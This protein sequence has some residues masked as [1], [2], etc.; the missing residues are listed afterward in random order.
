[1]GKENEEAKD[2][3]TEKVIE[4]TSEKP[5][6]NATLKNHIIASMGVG[7][8][9]L[10]LVDLVALTGIQVNMLRK[11]AKSYD[12][13]FFQDKVKNILASL[14]GGGLP[15]TLSGVF[16]SLL[17]SV[18]IVGQT[19]GALAMTILAG[20]TTYAVG[21]VF[22]QHFESGGTFLNFNPDSVRQYY[23]AMFKEGQ[24]I[25]ENLKK[26]KSAQKSE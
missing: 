14:I 16:A 19:T 23:E 25:T 12:I 5:D 1:M 20:A 22:I 21:K 6:I 2:A 4:S 7:L 17:K 11:L 3:K 8:I 15:V 26:E 9:P 18:P 13:P 10:P 24:S